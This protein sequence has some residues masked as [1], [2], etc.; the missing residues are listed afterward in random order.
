MAVFEKTYQAVKEFES[1]IQAAQEAFKV[2]Q[3]EILDTYKD[4][5]ST[6][7]L[8]EARE[9]LTQT[10]QRE[11][12][13][14]LAAVEGD[15]ASVT[16][17]IMEVVTKA[18]PADFPATLAALQAKG[19]KVSAYEANAF[20]KKYGDNYIA[21][22]TLLEVLHSNGKADSVHITTAEMIDE[23]VKALEEKIVRWIRNRHGVSGDASYNAKILTH[24][25]HSP[26]LM[27]G[28]EVQNFLD[29][30]FIRP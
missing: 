6:R 19:D 23:K 21:I 12:L 3:K 24:E 20:F 29:G 10:E 4:P 26:I 1:G 17:K 13:L 25:T 9:L 27:L 15:F 22:S 18:A 28:A 30:N 2:A 7:K 16:E 11:T 14:A 5:V 8:A